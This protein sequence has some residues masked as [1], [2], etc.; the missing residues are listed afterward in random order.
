MKLF[1]GGTYTDVEDMD[2]PSSTF[3]RP[4]TWTDLIYRAA[5]DASRDRH[6]VVT[7]YPLE[8]YFGV[9][10]CKI[11]VSSTM[12]TCAVNISGTDYP[13][14]P[15]IDLSLPKEDIGMIFR[16]SLAV[17]NLYMDIIGGDFDGDQVT[18]RGL[19]TDEANAAAHRKI[20]SKS[21]LLGIDGS[22]VRKIIKEGI[23]CIYSLTTDNG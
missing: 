16:D 22:F 20:Y 15:V 9:F 21:N 12:E 4:M 18:V 19:F 7:R 3:N 10:I 1:I 11:N 8:D 17:S 2:K 5:V 23:Q 14:Y 13:D 6:I